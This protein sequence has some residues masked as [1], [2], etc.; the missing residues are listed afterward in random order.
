M[1]RLWQ[2]PAC[3]TKMLARIGNTQKIARCWNQRISESKSWCGARSGLYIVCPYCQR[4]K[5]G[6]KC[7]RFLALALPH[8]SPAHKWHAEP[9]A[10]V[11]MPTDSKQKNTTPCVLQPRRVRDHK[12]AICAQTEKMVAIP[13]RVRSFR[14]GWLAVWP[15][16]AAR[17][18]AGATLRYALPRSTTPQ[19]RSNEVKRDKSP[20]MA[21]K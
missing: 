19:L 2:V 13:V 11:S 17:L 10:A 21:W 12:S 1:L 16:W 14:P 18:S 4:R 9:M 8:F 15:R 5:K 20:G 6:K 3:A 7:W